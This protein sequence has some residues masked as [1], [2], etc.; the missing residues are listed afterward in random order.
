LQLPEGDIAA[1]DPIA[2]IDGAWQEVAASMMSGLKSRGVPP[3]GH[4]L[5]YMPGTNPG[6]R[7]LDALQVLTLEH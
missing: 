7:A 5:R 2:M 4:I 1:A 3:G 6:S